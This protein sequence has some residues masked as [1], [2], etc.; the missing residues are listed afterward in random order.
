MGRFDH[1]YKGEVSEQVSNTKKS[2]FYTIACQN[3]PL[4]TRR[5]H[6]AAYVFLVGFGSLPPNPRALYSRILFVYLSVGLNISY[7]IFPTWF[8]LRRKLCTIYGEG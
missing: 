4:F 2:Y 6:E 1:V 7:V 5:K 8:N 3:F